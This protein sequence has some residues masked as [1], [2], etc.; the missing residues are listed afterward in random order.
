LQSN[1]Q[2]LVDDLTTKLDKIEHSLLAHGR[3]W[4]QSEL[5]SN[6]ILPIPSA[7]HYIFASKQAGGLAFI[8]PV[9]E[10][11]VQTIVQAM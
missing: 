4:M 1:L 9:H 10:N 2:K 11:H 5:L 6:P 3:N 8:E 7:P